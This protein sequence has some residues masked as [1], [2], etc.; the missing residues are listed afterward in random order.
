M[1]DYVETGGRCK[2]TL[3]LRKHRCIK[4]KNAGYRCKYCGKLL[5]TL[6]REERDK[7]KGL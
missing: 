5:F 7:R 2:Q 6:R 1:S 3:Y 4:Y